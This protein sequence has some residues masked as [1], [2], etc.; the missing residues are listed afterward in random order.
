MTG[1]SQWQAV[2]LTVAFVMAV[3]IV[4]S[5]CVFFLALRYEYLDRRAKRR[6]RRNSAP[7]RVI[8]GDKPTRDE[9]S[10]I[11]N[12]PHGAGHRWSNY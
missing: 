10:R 3:S 5:V 6:T 8:T 9:W 1:M 7:V 11:L 12:T 2:G 4:I